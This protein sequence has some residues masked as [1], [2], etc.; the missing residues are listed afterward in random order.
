MNLAKHF[1]MPE[2]VNKPPSG[3]GEW[4]SKD[5]AGSG[6]RSRLAS[7]GTAR[8][9]ALLQRLDKDRVTLRGMEG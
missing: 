4:A 7:A 1:T 3:I 8:A 2:L 9:K 5:Q 6:R